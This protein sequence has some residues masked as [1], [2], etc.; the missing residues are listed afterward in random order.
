MCVRA[1]PQAEKEAA[2]AA[3]A[4]EAQA[5]LDRIAAEEAAAAEEKRKEEEAAAAIVAAEKAAAE[6]LAAEKAGQ[7]S[8]WSAYF[9][10]YSIRRVGADWVHDGGGGGG[11]GEGGDPYRVK[12]PSIMPTIGNPASVRADWRGLTGPLV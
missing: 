9:I 8:L 4:A 6:K 3:A 10:G 11:G 2:E 5:E 7:N 12:P 1:S